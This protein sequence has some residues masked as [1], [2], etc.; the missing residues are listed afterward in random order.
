[1]KLKTAIRIGRDCGLSTVGEAI[2]NVQL[3]S[4]S[5]FDYDKVNAE[6]SELNEDF[7]KSGK[8]INEEI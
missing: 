2:C 8:S 6:L 5:M 4:S 7:L 1:M 3:H